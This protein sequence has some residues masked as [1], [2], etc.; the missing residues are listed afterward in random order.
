MS[1]IFAKIRPVYPFRFPTKAHSTD[2]GYDLHVCLR[3]A[4][5]EIGWGVRDDRVYVGE[6]GL[7]VIIDPGKTATLPTNL[8]INIPTGYVGIMELRSSS[9]R[10]GLRTS[11]VIDAGFRGE[12]KIC[13]QN[14][15]SKPFVVTDGMRLVQ[16]VV[17]SIFGG[18]EECVDVP[19]T[20]TTARGQ[21][22]F[23]STGV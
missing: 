20:E 16:L 9:M 8:Q 4:E 3:G 14:L 1:L 21:G 18:V 22:G 2:A 7:E 6:S 10:Q 23:G 15:G 19:L 11:G 5:V 12:V 17:H 13:L